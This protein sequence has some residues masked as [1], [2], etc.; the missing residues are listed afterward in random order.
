MN[1]SSIPSLAPEGTRSLSEAATFFRGTLEIEGK[2]AEVVT[3]A[4]GGS[5]VACTF[6]DT[7]GLGKGIAWVNGFNLG[8]Y[9]PTKGPQMTLYVPGPVLR[10]G[11][12][13]VL[14]LEVEKPSELGEKVNGK[15]EMLAGF[16][17]CKGVAHY[18]AKEIL[19]LYLINIS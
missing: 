7:T 14:I 4:G 11:S 13:D 5:H 12:N 2:A 16:I 3:N 8:W 1:P 10:E 18:H 15:F 9:W 19:K 6:L 17:W